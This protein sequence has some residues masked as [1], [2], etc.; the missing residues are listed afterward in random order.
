MV[1]VVLRLIAF[2]FPAPSGGVHATS[3]LARTSQNRCRESYRLST[4][5]RFPN[6]LNNP[7]LLA[8][9]GLFYTGLDDIVQCFR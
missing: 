6:G 4:F 5:L 8:A 9:S 2:S 3:A 7:T 1:K